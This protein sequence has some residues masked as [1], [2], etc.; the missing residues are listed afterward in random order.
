M[1]EDITEVRRPPLP[2]G[3]PA[4][5][6]PV[7]PGSVLGNLRLEALLNRGTSSEIYQA[8]NLLARK[9]C[10]V[11]VLH[12]PLVASRVRWGRYVHES[13][14]VAA[15][16]QP[17]IADVFNHQI[18]DGTGLAVMAPSP[19]KSLRELLKTSGPLS[20]RAFLPVVRA[21]GLALAPVH[22]AGLA[23]RRLHPGQILVHWTGSEPT[24]QLL[25]FGLHHLHVP[26]TE[27]ASPV[28][29]GVEQGL[30]VSPEQAKG[31]P[32][33]PRSDVYSLAVI[34]YQM[35]AGRP[36]FLGDTLKAVLDQHLSE[37]PQPPSRF[38]N[39]PPELEETLL[40]ALEKDARKRTPSVEA[41]LAAID[42]A[43]VTGQH[44]LVKA[45]GSVRTLGLAA[46]PSKELE[47]ASVGA[48]V[49]D[50]PAQ[51]AMPVAM[52]PGRVVAPRPPPVPADLKVPKSRLWMFIALGAVVLLCGGVLAYVLLGDRGETK[53]KPTAPTRTRTPARTRRALPSP[54]LP[55]NLRPPPEP[56]PAAGPAH[57]SGDQ[58]VAPRA[59]PTKGRPIIGPI[60]PPEPHTSTIEV[61]TSDSSAQILVDGKPRGTG[62]NVLVEGLVPGRH[63]V[64]IVVGG[65]PSAERIVLVRRGE[66]AQVLF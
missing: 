65:K 50:E 31:E 47:L 34:L 26:L 37:V 62:R 55:R 53:P 30:Y 58:V 49:P 35:I 38:I 7:R 42:P 16:R 33:D 44:L 2:P 25:D 23:H 13:K 3:S 32:G 12:P 56:A 57:V 15:L 22:A 24:I 27:E 14:T 6:A 8:Q 43:A 1:E 9:P 52:P 54:E 10:V 29:R 60:A 18:L 63:R 51:P 45:S 66:K 61:V 5:A 40:R 21:I 59:L 11:K 20:R 28:P 46:S 17:G 48:A 64:Q 19:G 39:T 36:P 41:M 4:P